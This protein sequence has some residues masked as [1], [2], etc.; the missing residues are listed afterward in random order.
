MGEVMR[1]L[2]LSPQFSS[3]KAYRSR[4]KSPVEYTVGAYRALD[5]Q[6]DGNGLPLFPLLM[7]QTVFDPPPMC[8]LAQRDQSSVRWLQWQHYG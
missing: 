6:G 2:L 1:T 4:I 8:W 5:L 3:T 7:G